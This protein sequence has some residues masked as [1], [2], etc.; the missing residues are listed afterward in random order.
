[1]TNRASRVSSGIFVKQYSLTAYRTELE[2]VFAEERNRWGMGLGSVFCDPSKSSSPA[3]PSHAEVAQS[4][5]DHRQS[6][7]MRAELSKDRRG[8]L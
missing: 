8:Y 3:M 7:I 6:Y 1:M 5:L 4:T 2:S